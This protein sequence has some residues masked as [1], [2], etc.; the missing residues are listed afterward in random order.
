MTWQKRLL[1]INSLND[2]I[3]LLQ[4]K[5]CL[6]MQCQMEKFSVIG[7]KYA[8]STEPLWGLK[9]FFARTEWSFVLKTQLKMH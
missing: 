6:N 8:Q 1:N 4:Q 9:L 3:F 5:E 7:K 2:A